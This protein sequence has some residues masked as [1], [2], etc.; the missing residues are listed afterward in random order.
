MWIKTIDFQMCEGNDTQC[1]HKTYKRS[2]PGDDQ[3]KFM[4]FTSFEK[5]S[6][7]N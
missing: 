5:M 3:D 6:S 4:N 1:L 2:H 7:I